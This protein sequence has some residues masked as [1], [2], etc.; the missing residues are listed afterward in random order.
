VGDPGS[1]LAAGNTGM[2][3]PFRTPGPLF[4]AAPGILSEKNPLTQTM[5]SN[6]VPCQ[7]RATRFGRSHDHQ[8][9][10]LPVKHVQ[11]LF[12]NEIGKR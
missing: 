4:Q 6:R 11:T 1:V 9:P 3:R 2:S 10:R 8:F 5:K 12:K 7:E